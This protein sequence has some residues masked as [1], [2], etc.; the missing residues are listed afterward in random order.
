M[1]MPVPFG[2][3]LADLQEACAGHRMLL[4]GA[5]LFDLQGALER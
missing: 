2:M 5:V 1:P 4:V 3:L